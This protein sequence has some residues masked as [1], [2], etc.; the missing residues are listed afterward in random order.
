MNK[1]PWLARLFLWSLF[2]FYLLPALSTAATIGLNAND[3]LTATGAWQNVASCYADDGLYTVGSGLAN[4]TRNFRVGLADPADTANQRITSVILY[5]KGYSNNARAKVRLIPYFAGAPGTSS[6]SYTFGMTEVL[7]SFD[8]TL[9]NSTLPD[10]TWN[11]DDIVNLSVQ[12][13]PRTA[14]TFSVNHI[15][16]VVRSRK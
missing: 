11:W 15:F 10:T 9:Q 1:Q 6:G 8:I 4:G 13:T 12:F 3:S 14:A 7:R 2:V 16:A 5:A